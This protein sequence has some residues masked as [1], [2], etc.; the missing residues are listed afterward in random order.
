M[1]AAGRNE[2]Y[3]YLQPEPGVFTVGFFNPQGVWHPESDH[4]S[5]DAA[6]ARV[7]YLNGGD[8]G[9]DKVQ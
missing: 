3:V 5:T 4:T 1:N 2:M 9:A 6:A 8:K 7:N